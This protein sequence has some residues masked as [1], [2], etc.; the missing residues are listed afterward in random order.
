[1]IGNLVYLYL[2]SPLQVLLN[3]L[4]E[5]DEIAAF[6]LAHASGDDVISLE[7]EIAEIEKQRCN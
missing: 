1:M 7:D 4:E 2:L 5:L 6:D 3:E